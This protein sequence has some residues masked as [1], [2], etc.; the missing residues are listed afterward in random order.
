MLGALQTIACV[1]TGLL[2]AAARLH[3]RAGGAH[4]RA[5]PGLAAAIGAAFGIRLGGGRAPGG[6]VIA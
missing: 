1:D 5:T 4:E 6:S 3:R 2:V